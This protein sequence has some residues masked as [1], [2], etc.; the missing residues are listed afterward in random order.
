MEKKALLCCRVLVLCNLPLLVLF[1]VFYKK[2]VLEAVRLLGMEGH[3]IELP[4]FPAP[5]K[6]QYDFIIS[7]PVSKGELIS[8]SVLGSVIIDG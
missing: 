4:I 3:Q 5:L 2:K 1:E 6:A 8:P 7:T